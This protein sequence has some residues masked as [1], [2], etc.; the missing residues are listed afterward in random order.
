MGRIRLN[1]ATVASLMTL[2]VTAS[3]GAQ[4]P[5]QRTM[6]RHAWRWHAPAPSGAHVTF[7]VPRGYGYLPYGGYYGY[8]NVYGVPPL[9][10]YS[11]YG[12]S[13][14]GNTAWPVGQSQVAT[15]QA[16][17]QYLKNRALFNEI[18]RDQRKAIEARKAKEDDERWERR[19]RNLARAGRL[20][21]DL[22]KRLTIDQLDATTGKVSW[23]KSLLRTEFDGGRSKI[24]TA[25]SGIAEHGPDEKTA[26]VIRAAAD[27]MKKATNSLMAEIGFEDY[28]ETRKFLSSLSAEGYYAIDDL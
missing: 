7:Q 27:Q 6:D 17:E 28:T 24:E 14:Y 26:G 1:R 13:A 23:P 19:A 22:Y 12:Y 9:Y 2:L 8:G 18:R 16:R 5:G 3:A 15:E 20:P 10:G 25:L 11:A 4:P 21:S